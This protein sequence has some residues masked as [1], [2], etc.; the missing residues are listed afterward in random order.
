MLVRSDGGGDGDG[1]EKR[2]VMSAV[3]WAG[4]CRY[5]AH[6]LCKGR[7][8]SEGAALISLLGTKRWTNCWR[9]KRR[10]RRRRRTRRKDLLHA[11]GGE[12]II[13]E[14]RNAVT[15]RRRRKSDPKRERERE[16]EDGMDATGSVHFPRKL[17]DLID[18][19]LM[20]AEG[21]ADAIKLRV[22]RSMHISR[23]IT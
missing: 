5:S 22:Y 23:K 12:S 20:L 19:Q 9:R 2:D 4:G 16:R 1:R 11:E 13:P 21:S 17:C 14:R 10:K 15:C 7:G 8:G 3:R 6:Y 18:K